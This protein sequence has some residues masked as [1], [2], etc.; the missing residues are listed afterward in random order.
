M[1]PDITMFPHT[2]EG[3]DFDGGSSGT[4]P[5]LRFTDHDGQVVN[6][7]LN[8]PAAQQLQQLVRAMLDA[9]FGPQPN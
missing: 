3:G 7:L 5:G 8:R 2:I 1:Q 4:F 9:D 6:V